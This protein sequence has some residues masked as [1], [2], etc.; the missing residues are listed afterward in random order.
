MGIFKFGMKVFQFCQ[1][2]SRGSKIRYLEMVSIKKR[3]GFLSELFKRPI[4]W[5]L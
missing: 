5:A 1:G 4:E 2:A 3:F